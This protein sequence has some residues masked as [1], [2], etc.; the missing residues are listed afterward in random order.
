MLCV[1]FMIKCNWELG[2]KLIFNSPTTKVIFM[3][4]NDVESFV[5]V[6]K[7]FNKDISLFKIINER[8]TA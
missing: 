8:L 1:K 2:L 4:I 5:E 7:K 3:S 6:I